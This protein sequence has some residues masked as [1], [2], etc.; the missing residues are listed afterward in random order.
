[1]L[2]METVR[3]APSSE[4]LLL[5]SWIY[6]FKPEMNGVIEIGVGTGATTRGWQAM[7]AEDGLYAGID[8]N[9][10][11]VDL[12]GY[13]PSG[14]DIMQDVIEEFKDDKRMTFLIGDSHSSDIIEQ[15]KQLIGNH[16]IDLLFI[17][18]AHDYTDTRQDFDNYAPFV[19]HGGMIVFH[20]GTC[21]GHVRRVIQEEVTLRYPIGHKES[22]F[23]YKHHCQFDSKEGHCGIT[24]LVKE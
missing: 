3:K 8:L 20:D 16:D 23:P 11:G 13:N 14:R 15:T 19:Q 18:G 9:I 21:N 2:L 17:D 24:V 4:H 22:A 12:E 1:M 5:Y 6:G 7:L 10:Y